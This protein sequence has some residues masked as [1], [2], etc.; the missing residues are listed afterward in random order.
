MNRN[1]VSLAVLALMSACG[2]GEPVAYEQA[3][4]E[5]VEGRAQPL[6]PVDLP[7]AAVPAKE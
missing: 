4:T 1:A 2:G 7:L 3:V 6:L 5:P